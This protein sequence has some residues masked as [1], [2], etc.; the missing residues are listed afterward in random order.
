MRMCTTH[1]HYQNHDL[2]W[3]GWGGEEGCKQLIV[4]AL[5]YGLEDLE[6]EQDKAYL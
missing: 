6:T 3:G 2:S 1:L 5:C 4:G